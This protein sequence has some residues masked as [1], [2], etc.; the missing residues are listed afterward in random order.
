MT[1][2]TITF[3][4]LLLIGLVCCNKSAYD[5]ESGNAANHQ[6][7]KGK[8]ILRFIFQFDKDVYLNS[9]YGEPPQLS[10]WL[11][12]SS[13]GKIQIIYVTHRGG[14]NDWIGKINCPVALPYWESRLKSN[15]KEGKINRSELDA[16]SSA[17]TKT[18]SLSVEALLDTGSVWT[19]YIEANVAGDYNN[20]FAP[21]LKNGIIDSEG[22]GQPSIVYREKI[23][24]LKNNKSE[25]ILIGRTFQTTV[26][27]TLSRDLS[28]ITTAKDVIKK[29]EVTVL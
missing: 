20:S 10:V 19:Y 18:G 8:A 11:E 5:E 7:M 26:K 9:I 13:G 3:L 1:K 6:I 21:Y 28:G 2:T 22:N 15:S 4:L 17:T 16:V 25:P 14:M 27:D 24:I 12:D 23:K 29:I